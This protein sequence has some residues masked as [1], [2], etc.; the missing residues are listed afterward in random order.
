MLRLCRRIRAP[1]WA[2]GRC[3]V[4]GRTW[5]CLYSTVD[6][7]KQPDHIANSF[8]IKPKLAKTGKSR[9]TSLRHVPVVSSEPKRTNNE[10]H[11]PLKTC[12]TASTC[13]QYDLGLVVDQFYSQGL[14]SATILL[15]GEMAHVRYPYGAGR[16]ADVLV[17]ANGTV[18]A[19]GMT[20]TEVSGHILSLLKPAEIRPYKSAETE[21][22]DYVDEME[23]VEDIIVLEQTSPDTIPERLDK[24]SH[25]GSE[26]HS[27]EPSGMVG[28]VIYI[29][30][31][32]V[33][34]RLL[35]KAAF[36]SGLARNTKL[37]ALEISLDN[38]IQS[39]KE[40]SDKLATGR[41]IGLHGKGVLKIT[42][43]L[44]QIRGQ[45][46]LYS[47]LI[48]TPD[49]YWSEPE[50]ESLYSLISR[51]LDVAPRIAILNKKLDYASELVAILKTHISEEK[52]IRLEWMII[53][54]IT[55]EV[56]FEIVHLADKYWPTEPDNHSILDSDGE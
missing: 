53:I 22:M 47:E 54:L 38:Y 46:N 49:L 21:D 29:R 27:G 37:A 55:V 2:P 42:G 52:S 4:F 3:I 12:T 18:V 48:E 31:E 5:K 40:L 41:K 33:S 24:R 14:R 11:P 51:K 25:D 50:L 7:T 32:N 15:P 45:L 36:S 8:K 1:L 56:C 44:L 39:I 10:H 16:S 19:W 43:Q 26:S 20:E 23:D 13:E 6:T 30:G 34:L 17:L 28:D 9:P 35:D